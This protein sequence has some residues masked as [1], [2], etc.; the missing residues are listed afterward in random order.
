M[1]ACACVCLCLRVRTGSTFLNTKGWGPLIWLCGCDGTQ[2]AT[3]VSH[4]HTHT[5]THTHNVSHWT[6][7]DEQILK[8]LQLQEHQSN[9]W[10]ENNRTNGERNY[11]YTRLT[12]CQRR[13]HVCL[14]A[15][16][17]KALWLK[18]KKH[19]NTSHLV[20]QVTAV[21]FWRTVLFQNSGRSSLMFQ[22]LQDDLEENKSH[23]FSSCDD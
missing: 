1:C 20:L 13:K 23:K 7:W 17:T 15:N 3:L 6:T 22:E 11:I 8:E 5:H 9:V 21:V 10:Q 4:T 2:Q 12:L 19:W 14:S 18:W 16:A